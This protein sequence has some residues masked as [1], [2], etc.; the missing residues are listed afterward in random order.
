MDSKQIESTISPPI[1]IHLSND[2]ADIG[3]EKEKYSNEWIT[4]LRNMLEA[5]APTKNELYISPQKNTQK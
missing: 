4:K 5:D 3:I 2:Q 1:N